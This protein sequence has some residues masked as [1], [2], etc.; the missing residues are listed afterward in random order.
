MNFMNRNCS[1]DLSIL[2]KIHLTAEKGL[3][4]SM[5]LSD[6]LGVGFHEAWNY[7]YGF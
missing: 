7:R 6:D 4:R 5:E 3:A 2:L 1:N